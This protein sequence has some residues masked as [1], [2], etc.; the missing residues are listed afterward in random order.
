MPLDL[1]TVVS[2]VSRTGRLVV[3]EPGWLR[4]GAAAEVVAGV[5]EA[6]GDRLKAKPRRIAWPQ[7]YVATS[8]QLE[9]DFYPNADNIVAACK[10]SMS[11]RVTS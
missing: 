2:S 5:V 4:F 1:D 11:D 8:S 6:V 7:S 9:D 10:A 3:A